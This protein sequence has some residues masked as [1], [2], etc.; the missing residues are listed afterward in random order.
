MAEDQLP[1]IVTDH[2]WNGEAVLVWGWQKDGVTIPSLAPEIIRRFKRFP[3]HI[4]VSTDPDSLVRAFK[5]VGGVPHRLITTLVVETDLSARMVNIIAV[6]RTDRDLVEWIHDHFLSSP[7]VLVAHWDPEDPDLRRW[8]A[9]IPKKSSARQFVRS[10]F[11]WPAQA[12]MEHSSPLDEKWRRYWRQR[13]SLFE[14]PIDGYLRSLAHDVQPPIP[15]RSADV[16]EGPPFRLLDYFEEK[17]E[18]SFFG[19]GQEA[20]KL[21][22]MA[23][24]HSLSLLIGPSGVGKTSLIMAGATPKIKS[25]WQRQILYIRPEDDPIVFYIRPKDDPIGVSPEN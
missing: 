25:Q 9:S 21:A 11:A 16:P 18:H 2:I 20:Q 6:D 23:L 13:W 7:V 8:Y 24:G 17:H 5:Q 1:P 10:V 14:R 19:R 3:F 12:D 22:D 4:I 15:A